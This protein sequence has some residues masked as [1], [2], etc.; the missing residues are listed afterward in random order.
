M[1]PRLR[2]QLELLV[3]RRRAR[4]VRREHVRLDPERRQMRRELQR[5]LHASAA[6]RRKVERHEQD[7]QPSVTAAT[8]RARRQRR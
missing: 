8:V 4:H 3:R 5:P 6:A 1:D 7:L 2:R